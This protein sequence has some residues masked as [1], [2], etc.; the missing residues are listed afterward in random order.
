LR[1]ALQTTVHTHEHEHGGERHVHVHVHPPKTHHTAESAHRHTH[2]AF[3]IGIL[4]GLAGSS[5]LLGILPMLAFPTQIQAICYLAA[6]T[7][8][9][10][11]SMMGFS[12]AMGFAAQHAAGGGLRFYRSLMVCC[13]VGAMVVGCVWIVQTFGTH[14]VS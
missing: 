3:G 4:H 11:L 9:T 8:G 5:H 13:G 2:A 10:V 7:A 12:W 14:A 1:K 6:F